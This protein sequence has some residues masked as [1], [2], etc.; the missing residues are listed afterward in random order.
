[1]TVIAPKRENSTRFVYK[2]KPSVSGGLNN[3]KIISDQP[4]GPP[5]KNRGQQQVLVETK[6]AMFNFIISTGLV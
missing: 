4:K 5:F 6:T 3:F 1:M 2:K